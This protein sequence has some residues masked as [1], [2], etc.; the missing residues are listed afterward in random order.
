LGKSIRQT[1]ES[2]SERGRRRDPDSSRTFSLGLMQP[3]YAYGG[4]F[5]ALDTERSRGHVASSVGST[6]ISPF[7]AAGDLLL[8]HLQRREHI[9]WG[10]D[11]R[12]LHCGQPFAY[13]GQVD[14]L[15]RTEPITLPPLSPKTFLR[16]SERRFRHSCSGFT[17]FAA[18]VL[19]RPPFEAFVTGLRG[20]G[21]PPSLVGLFRACQLPRRIDRTPRAGFPP[22]GEVRLHCARRTELW[23]TRPA[24]LVSYS[25]R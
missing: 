20:G 13:S 1:A 2:G 7:S 23:G 19:A 22:A 16:L 4:D 18:C 9:R 24:P 12:A 25:L 11:H 17:R 8:L 10:V 3:P 21:H 5:D 14:H 6:R 15:F